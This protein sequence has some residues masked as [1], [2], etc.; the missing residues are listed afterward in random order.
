VPPEQVSVVIHRQSIVHS[1]VEFRDGAVLAQLGTADMRLPIRYA[2]TYPHRAGTELP[3]LDL[4]TTPPLTFQ[5]PDLEAFPCLA[6]AME[7]AKAG[8]T[9]CAV[10]NAANEEAVG[11]FLREEIAFGDIPILVERALNQV[12]GTSNPTLAD[13]LEADRKARHIVQQKGN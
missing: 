5:A 8:G 6:L 7:A 10:L 1:M 4:L 2:L 3:A 11:M 9:A 13:I 12:E